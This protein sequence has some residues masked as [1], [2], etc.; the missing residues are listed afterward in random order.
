MTPQ[1][2]KAY[3]EQNKQRFKEQG[4][5]IRDAK[6]NY[7]L[8]LSIIVLLVLSGFVLVYYLSEKELFKSELICGDTLVEPTIC[9]ESKDC[10]CNC[11][12]TICPE[13]PDEIDINLDVNTLEVEVTN[14]TG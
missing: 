11:E 2:K 8:T 14:G 12:K 13:F 7:L 9:P 10:I 4:I 6:L 3:I 5:I 1:Q